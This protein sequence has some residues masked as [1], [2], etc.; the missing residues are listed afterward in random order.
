MGFY[1]WV[2]VAV[3]GGV[4][5]AATLCLSS[6]L[7]WP[8]RLRSCELQAPLQPPDPDLAMRGGLGPGQAPCSPTHPSLAGAPGAQL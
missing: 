7:V 2:M 8:L 3:T 4:G 5:V 1:H 6:L